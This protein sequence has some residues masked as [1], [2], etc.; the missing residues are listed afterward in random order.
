MGDFDWIAAI[1]A[2]QGAFSPTAPDTQRHAVGWYRH[3]AWLSLQWR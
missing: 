2:G 3:E 1:S